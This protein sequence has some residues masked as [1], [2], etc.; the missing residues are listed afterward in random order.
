MKRLLLPLLAVLALPVNAEFVPGYATEAERG[1]AL[2]NFNRIKK[3][4]DRY[5]AEDATARDKCR[6]L[7]DIAFKVELNE[8][9]L[10]YWHPRSTGSWY[11]YGKRIR[12]MHNETC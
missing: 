4:I 3:Y 5:S 11:D 2:L 6:A 9:P 8:E 1:R 12:K 10:D 7:W